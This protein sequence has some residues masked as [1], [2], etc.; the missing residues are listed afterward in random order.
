MFV[1][2]LRKRLWA[3]SVSQRP[4]FAFAAVNSS[5]QS[6]SDE[7]CLRPSL[8]R[9]RLIN[10]PQHKNISRISQ[11]TTPDHKATHVFA[12]AYDSPAHQ[13]PFS[14]LFSSCPST[15]VDSQAAFSPTQHNF[16][17]NPTPSWLLG[18][19][20]DP[21]TLHGSSQ[22]SARSSHGMAK[23]VTHIFKLKKE[24]AHLAQQLKVCASA[25]MRRSYSS[26]RSI[27]SDQPS[28]LHCV[29][30]VS[31]EQA[32]TTVCVIVLNR[33]NILINFSTNA[34]LEYYEAL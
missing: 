7:E 4:Y 26:F 27:S 10:T 9:K 15:A 20:P 29:Q 33:C 3:I 1:L 6:D 31:L 22:Q 14:A 28:C 32:C 5:A 21:S 12:T 11:A 30:S 19:S 18:T 34:T 24:H 25:S 13:T 17:G 23:V 2:H 8:L 16:C